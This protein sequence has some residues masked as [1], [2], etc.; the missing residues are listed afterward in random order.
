MLYNVLGIGFQ[1]M[2]GTSVQKQQ[3]TFQYLPLLIWVMCPHNI[4]PSVPLNSSRSDA[5]ERDW[6]SVKN[7][8]SD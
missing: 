6:P 7:N 3:E 2:G 5:M 8:C 1:L 4:G